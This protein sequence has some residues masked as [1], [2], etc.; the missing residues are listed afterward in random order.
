MWKKI[1]NWSWY[2]VNE[3]GVVYNSKTKKYLSGDVNNCGYH[4]IILYDKGKKQRIFIHRLVATLFIPNPNNYSEVNH[5]DGNKNNNQVTNLEWCDRTHNE[6]E[7]RRL[8]L[9]IYKPFIV[10]FSNGETKTYEFAQELADEIQVSKRTVL[11]YLHGKTKGYL[12]RGI[13]SIQ[14]L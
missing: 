12:N 11:N 10:Y 6:H 9:K 8:G 13:K 4:R 1:P 2:L 5:I 7:A 3:Q 14:Y